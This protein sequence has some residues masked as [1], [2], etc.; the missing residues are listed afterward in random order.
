[1]ETTSRLAP[2]TLLLTLIVFCLLYAQ[3]YAASPRIGLLRA[4]TPEGTGSI[5][6]GFRDGLREQG[7]KEGTNIAIESRFAN[8][9]V[10]GA[11]LCAAMFAFAL[12]APPKSCQWGNEAYSRVGSLV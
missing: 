10:G 9:L 5:L 12:V 1:M 6:A 11:T 8:A 3:S 2:R 4:G 7:Y